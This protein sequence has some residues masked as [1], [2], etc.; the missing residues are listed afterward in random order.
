MSYTNPSAREARIGLKTFI[1]NRLRVSSPPRTDFA[2]HRVG[3]SIT[4]LEEPIMK[5]AAQFLMLAATAGLAM[6]AA[7]T[8]KPVDETGSREAV[9]A[10]AETDVDAWFI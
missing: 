5:I 9:P 10:P 7:T 8:R 1:G 4:T 6:F 3:P 2:R